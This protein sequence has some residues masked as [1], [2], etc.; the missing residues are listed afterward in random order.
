MAER[1]QLN[2]THGNYPD[3]S[4]IFANDQ[5]CKKKKHIVH[6]GAYSV[7]SGHTCIY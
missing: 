3:N 1:K 5:E 6:N 2:F 4:C 7:L